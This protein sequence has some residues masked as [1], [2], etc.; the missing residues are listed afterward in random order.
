MVGASDWE[1]EEAHM[2]PDLLG[3]RSLPRDG[4]EKGRNGMSYEEEDQYEAYGN[5]NDHSVHK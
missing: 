4:A 3:R 2:P 1:E 5:I